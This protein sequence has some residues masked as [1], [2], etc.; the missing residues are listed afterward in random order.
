MDAL[1]ALWNAMVQG[2][3][4]P[5]TDLITNGPKYFDMDGGSKIVRVCFNWLNYG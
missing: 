3:T 2:C 1:V 5:I 4:A